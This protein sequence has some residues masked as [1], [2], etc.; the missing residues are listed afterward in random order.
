MTNETAVDEQ[1]EVT[2]AEAPAQ[3]SRGNSLSDFADLKTR[4]ENG[5]WVEI[6][7]PD[8]GQPIGWRWLVAGPDSERQRKARLEVAAAHGRRRVARPLTA[9]EQEADGIQ[10]SA[11]CVIDWK[12]DDDFWYDEPNKVKPPAC[13]LR[14]VLKVYEKFPFVRE[15]ITMEVIDRAGFLKS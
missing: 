3:S 14:E 2:T 7:R 5:I 15:Q 10:I 9:A 13:S 11:R 6:L 4:Q 8:N 12:C 1:P